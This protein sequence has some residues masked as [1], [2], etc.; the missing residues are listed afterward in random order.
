MRRVI[1]LALALAAPAAAGDVL[2]VHL[3]S[4][5]VEAAA[6]LAEAMT[7][8]AAYLSEKVP[9]GELEVRLFRRWS[10][11]DRFLEDSGASVVLQLTDAS[12]L[13]DQ[14]PGSGLVPTHR[15]R[16]AGRGTFRRLVVVRADSGEPRRLV[17]LK[18]KTLVVVDTAGPRGPSFLERAVFEGEV[19]P[20]AW[21]GEL[22]SEVDDFSA[23]NKVLFG[24]ADS[25]LISADNPLVE[26]HLGGDLRAVYT[27]P[28]LSLPVLAVRDSA[29]DA[30][31]RAALDRALAELGRDPRGR[32]VLERLKLDGFEPLDEAA[33]RAVAELPR[34]PR[35]ELEVALPGPVEL[36]LELD[37]PPPAGELPFTI[38]VEIPDVPLP[39]A[40]ERGDGADG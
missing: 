37:P 26:S 4:A 39:R 34:S 12:F 33:A 25:A 10:D 21:F 29:F 32:R 8:L 23:A 5:P 14:G 30:A 40:G 6:H 17:D 13:I 9:G 22:E 35:K 15:L 19:D 36:G 31:R 38:A 1:L 11:A 2:L 18:G 20:L 16:R 7:D 24:Q 27:S 3:P 28:P